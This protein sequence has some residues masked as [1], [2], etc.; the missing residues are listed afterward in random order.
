MN[1]VAETSDVVRVRR[2]STPRDSERRIGGFTQQE[3][4]A[5]NYSEYP[6]YSFGPIGPGGW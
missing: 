4:L 5:R 2:P 6:D 1:A 3:T